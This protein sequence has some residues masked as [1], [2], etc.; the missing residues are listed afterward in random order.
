MT[1]RC[2]ETV[3]NLADWAD[4]PLEVAAV[5]PHLRSCGECARLVGR[6]RQTAAALRAVEPVAAP[7]ALSVETVLAGVRDEVCEETTVGDLL[8]SALP[9][10][11]MPFDV[12]VAGELASGISAERV[13]TLLERALPPRRG[14]AW[15]WGRV[16]ADLRTWLGSQRSL[17]RRKVASWVAATLMTAAAVVVAARFAVEVW[18]PPQLHAALRVID[19]EDPLDPSLSLARIMEEAARPAERK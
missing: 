13:S 16:R 18:P 5:D 6:A 9:P 3:A 1:A 8:R 17:K 10:V 15:V 14:P 4:R 12:P 2:R 7:A 11:P 19:S